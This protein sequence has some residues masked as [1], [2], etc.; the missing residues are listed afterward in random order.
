MALRHDADHTAWRLPPAR[1][2]DEP[3]LDVLRA[4][5]R[6]PRCRIRR[7][8]HQGLLERSVGARRGRLGTPGGASSWPRLPLEEPDEE[9]LWQLFRSWK[10]EARR[11]RR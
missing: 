8:R 2:P 10:P 7:E 6:R 9:S 1:T 4:K 3:S 5:P 11:G